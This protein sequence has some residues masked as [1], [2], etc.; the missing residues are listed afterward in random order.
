[1]SFDQRS[2]ETNNRINFLFV[3]RH[4]NNFL[5]F[6]FP[7]DKNLLQGHLFNRME[8]IFHFYSLENNNFILTG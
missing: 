2:I 3:K 8:L 1:M 6:D 7:L 5:F 4:G